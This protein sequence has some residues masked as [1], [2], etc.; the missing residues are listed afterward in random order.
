M[1]ERMTDRARRTIVQAQEE[2]RQLR[3]HHIGTEHIL[4]ALL[5]EPE[6]VAHQALTD[7]GITY[8]ET[9]GAVIYLVASSTKQSPP[10]GYITFTP[11]T[12]KVFE[13]ALREALQL[14]VNYIGTEHL[15][16]GLIR[17]HEGVAAQILNRFTSRP[18]T[19]GSIIREKVIEILQ[20]E[21]TRQQAVALREDY[22]R[23]SLSVKQRRLVE[24]AIRAAIDAIREDID[25]DG[26]DDGWDL[27]ALTVTPLDLVTEIAEKVDDLSQR[28]DTLEQ[29]ETIE[30]PI[31]LTDTSD[32]VDS[33]EQPQEDEQ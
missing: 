11:R 15:L 24:T 25:D 10:D 1:F 21:S 30:L 7:L 8:T 9:R 26:D 12:K 28:L 18:A 33:P 16:L 20:G 31:R 27:S 19:T 2:A 13:L 32:P 14:G 6:G 29:M 22:K 4:L 17:E 3:H 5:Q 23:R